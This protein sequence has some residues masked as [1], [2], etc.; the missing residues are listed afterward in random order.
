L[1]ISAKN[2]IEDKEVCFELGAD[3]YLSK[4]FNPKELLLRIKALNKRLHA[5]DTEK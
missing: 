5:P 3:D 1:I 2:R 4:P